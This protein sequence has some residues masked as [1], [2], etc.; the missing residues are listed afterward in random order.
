MGLFDVIGGLF[1]GETGAEKELARFSTRPFTSRSTQSFLPGALR[2][3][4]TDP[5]LQ[6]GIE[7][8]GDLIQNPGRLAPN[9]GDAIRQR[10]ATTSEG[11]AGNFRGIRANQAGA[12]ARGNLPLSIRTALGSALDVAQSRAQRGA[13][14]E[15]LTDTDQ[16]RRQDLSMIFPLL[17]AILQFTT[18]GRSAGLQG[19]GQAAQSSAQRQASTQALIGS[20][21]G[22]FATGGFGGGGSPTPLPIGQ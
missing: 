20:L 11:I 21:L 1:G 7:G 6:S 5:I 13:R 8:I 16:L 9:V 10:L 15:A 2:L 4:T 14:R 22:G 18:A 19:L 12:A 17:D 3:E